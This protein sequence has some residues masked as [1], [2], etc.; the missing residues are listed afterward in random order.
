[1][2]ME[3]TAAKIG[4]SMKKCEIF[5]SP[6][7]LSVLLRHGSRL[8]RALLRRDLLPWTRAQQ[9]DH[10]HVVVL[11]DPA[12]DDAQIAVAPRPGL[13]RLRHHG[14]ARRQGKPQL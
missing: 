14:P 11:G 5:I 12:P 1:M 3:M 8:G 4:R 13:D 2:M 10:D 7:S 6:R 9:P